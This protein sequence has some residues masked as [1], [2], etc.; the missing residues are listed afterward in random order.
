MNSYQELLEIGRLATHLGCTME[1]AAKKYAELP[2]SL[3]AEM[4]AKA[5]VKLRKELNDI[6]SGT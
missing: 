3:I 4:V 2:P 1:E 6:R 5:E